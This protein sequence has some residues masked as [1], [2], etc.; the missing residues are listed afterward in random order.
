MLEL[1]KVTV[2]NEEKKSHYCLPGV[3]SPDPCIPYV[4][5]PHFGP[6]DPT[7]ICSP[8]G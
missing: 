4:C 5:A 7:G 6:C 1:K 2:G 3:C 8:D